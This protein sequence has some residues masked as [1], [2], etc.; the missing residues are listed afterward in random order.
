MTSVFTIQHLGDKLEFTQLACI[1]GLSHIRCL[2]GDLLGCGAYIEAHSPC[3]ANWKTGQ[4]VFLPTSRSAPV[5]SYS[6]PSPP[7][8]ISDT[9]RPWT[10]QAQ[11]IAMALRENLAVVISPSSLTVYSLSLNTHVKAV[12]LLQVITFDHSVGSVSISAEDE[13]LPPES[14]TEKER[15]NANA[16]RG[17][18]QSSLLPSPPPPA[19]TRMLLFTAASTSIT[20]LRLQQHDA[21]VFSLEAIAESQLKRGD[22]LSSRPSLPHFGGSIARVSWIYAPTSFFDRSASLVTGRFVSSSSSSTSSSSSSPLLSPTRP[23]SS[24]T[25]PS[26][27]S[28]AKFEIMSECKDAQLPGFHAMPVMDYDDG[29]GLVVLGNACGELAVCNYAGP[30]TDALVRCFKPIPVPV[31]LAS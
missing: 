30:V 20:V 3:V 13:A 29:A 23:P 31:A 16:E 10:L 24:S 26:S 6:P 4:V 25:P 17:D 14:E 22:I 7:M 27:P 21:T 11:C 19:P 28:N 2:R 18:S 8:S 9:S 5:S 15:A 1:D 12:E